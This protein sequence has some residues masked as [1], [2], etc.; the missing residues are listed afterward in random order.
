M[1]L[2]NG[3]GHGQAPQTGVLHCGTFTLSAAVRQVVTAFNVLLKMSVTNAAFVLKILSLLRVALLWQLQLPLQELSWLHPAQRAECREFCRSFASWEHS[4]RPFAFR[5][6]WVLGPAAH[7]G[8]VRVQGEQAGHR[9]LPGGVC[10]SVGCWGTRG[11]CGVRSGP[12][13]LLLW[14]RT[15]WEPCLRAL[16]RHWVR[17]GGREEI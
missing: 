4:W 1:Y 14:L 15:A 12:C 13:G 17:Q 7:W 2:T 5:E 6:A 16:P 11:A 8:A 3:A 10:K 9:S